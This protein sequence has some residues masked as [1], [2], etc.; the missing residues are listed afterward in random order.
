VITLLLCGILVSLTYLAIQGMSKR[1]KLIAAAVISGTVALKVAA[2]FAYRHSSDGQTAI[3]W[4]AI[5][6]Y[7]LLILVALRIV[8]QAWRHLREHSSRG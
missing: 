4:M 8:D 6:V 2:V 5:P 7:G 3:L 1:A